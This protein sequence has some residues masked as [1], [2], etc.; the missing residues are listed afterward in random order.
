MPLRRSIAPTLRR[1]ALPLLALTLLLGGCAARQANVRQDVPTVR[2]VKVRAYKGVD[3]DGSAVHKKPTFAQGAITEGLDV[4]ATSFWHFFPITAPFFPRFYLERDAW[5]EDARR[6]EYFYGVRGYFDA[7]VVSSQVMPGASTRKDPSKIERLASGEPKFVRIQHTV[8]EGDPS[9]VRNVHMNVLGAETKEEGEALAEALMKQVGLSIGKRFE[10][11]TVDA[12]VAA[13][14]D[15]LADRSFAVAEARSVIDVYPDE[16]AVDVTFVVSPGP[17]CVFGEVTI[18]G[19]EDVKTRYVERQILTEEGELYSGTKVRRTKANIYGMGVFSMVTLTPDYMAE[20]YDE[21]GRLIVPLLIALKERKPATF[22]YAPGFEWDIAGFQLKPADFSLSHIN[23][24]GL[25]V[26]GSLNASAGYRYLS[27]SDHFP[28]ATLGAELRWP[29]I[30]WRNASIRARGEVELGVERGYKFWT[31][32][33]SLG[34]AWTPKKWLAFD[35]SYNLQYYDLFEARIGPAPDVPSPCPEIGKPAGGCTP[36][37]TDAEPEFADNY[38]LSYF[39]EA[40]TF[41]LRDNPL[42]TNKGAFIQL[43]SEQ[44]FPFGRSS[45]GTLRGFRYVKIEAELRGYLPIVKD[46]FVLASRIGGA[47]FFTSGDEEQLPVNK[48]V[49]LGGDGTVRGFK[50][51][52]LGPRGL[53]A[54]CTRNDCIIPLGAR[55]G[56]SGSVELR[57]RPFSDGALSGLWLAVFTD[58]GRTWGDATSDTAE[59]DPELQAYEDALYPQSFPLQMSVGGGIR[60]DLSFGRVRIDFAHRLRRWPSE[61]SEFKEPFPWN[62][63]FNLSE[64]F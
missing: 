62:I 25:L 17:T 5:R 22:E 11:D 24:F 39:R 59:A 36:P 31:P 26:Q 7:T 64:S 13:I 47:H 20:T 3:K 50:T 53:E 52:Y 55:T 14:L 63:H 46:R 18:D 60:Y 35:V 12:S 51:K 33:G 32:S 43:A 19:L 48:A 15:A 61:I 37:S 29:E 42:A 30:P 21:Q 10:M 38:I 9:V 40:V 23:L 34:L 27:R 8:M 28:I 49:Y 16:Q 57:A 58:A 2:N 45:D 1:L 54:D 4:R 41:D 56:I 44:A 6:I